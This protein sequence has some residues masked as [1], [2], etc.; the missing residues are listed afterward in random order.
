MKLFLLAILFSA[1]T[2]TAFSQK[3]K[4]T[5]VAIKTEAP[6]KMD[7]VLDDAVWQNVPIATDFV[8]LQPNAGNHE[9]QENRTTVKII[10]DN[11]A[12]YVGARMYEKDPTKIAREFA[13]R[14]QVGNADFIG[15]IFDTYKDGINGSGF[16]VTSTNG[17]FDAKYAPNPNG[18]TED[19]TWNAVWTSKVNIDSLGWT[20]EMKIPYSALRFAKKDVQTWGMNLI[21]KRQNVQQQLFWN[22]L[23]PKMS[24]LMNQEGIL[25]GLEKIVPPVR[26][27]FYPYFST[28]V[29]HYPYNTPGLA[30]TT[31]SV[32]GGMDV[33][34]GIN[35]S[36]TLDLTLI[37]D[38][39]Q[40]QSDNRILNLT[41]FEVK[42]NENRSFFT[43]GTELFNK[44]N[45]FYSRR[46]GGQPLHYNDITLNDHEAIIKNP[47]E[48]KL[49]N[50]VKLSGRLSN[51]LGIGIF[52]GL[53]NTAYA[54]IEDSTTGN[55][56]VVQTSP[57]TNYNIIVLD[58]NLKNNSA[59]TFI[60]T[61][62]N[63][64]GKD[65]SAD[66]G[67][68][69]FNLNNKKNT[70]NLAGYGLMSNKFYKGEQT[71]TGYNYEV[72]FGKVAGNFTWNV[73]QD[74]VD[75][76]YD[77]N[78][79]G[80][81]FNNNYLEH[82]INLQYANYKPKHLFT[83]WNV[84]TNTYSS[85]RV[86]PSTYQYF[87][88]NFGANGSFKN[89]WQVN[90]NGH[91]RVEGNDFYEPRVVGRVFKAPQNFV[92]NWNLSTNRAKVLSGGFWYSDQWMANGHGGHGNDLELFYNVRL[93]N[94]FSFGQD[95]TI[96][97]RINYTGFATFDNTGAD[98]FALRN[99]HT[100]DNIFTLKYTFSSI[101]GL[102]LRLRHYWS[103]VNN[104]EFFSLG[105][106]GYLTS[107][108]SNDFNHNIDQNANI[109][110]VDMIY[111]WQFSPGSELSLA[112]KNSTYTN[113]N[114]ATQS[115]LRN[116]NDTVNQPQNNNFSLK[117][118][119]YIDFQS[120][121]KHRKG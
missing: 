103:K 45:L 5:L 35:E 55:R 30:N 32:N 82:N 118:L 31:T 121:R 79:L 70:Y 72:V 9:K 27:A 28:Y 23:D 44:G 49:I 36:F 57:V 73:S 51:G 1:I 104:K 6:P 96:S 114:I 110:N 33:K 83:Q 34:Y 3:P 37:P 48:T 88:Q 102:N 20:C 21:R 92:L 11:T 43:E 107:L 52:N 84:W 75:S 87:N 80:I 95:I 42:Y 25:T 74:R 68:V 13:T 58:Q 24:G 60:N 100:V 61:N 2:L 77:P 56:R 69:V 86:S 26:L 39:G 81:L 59:I 89:F 120:L 65:Y 46:V 19:E 116:L 90:I 53:T 108:T 71:V 66:V 111:V 117:V 105:Q 62:V 91:Y 112:W 119:Y 94:K 7:G 12:I 64:F 15:I 98:V 113:T 4:K 85:Y 115:Y 8:E 109:W 63:R 67:G 97:P 40:V 18:N 54:T 16:F 22:E 38:F 41:P 17:Q 78:D 47:T 101:M 93:S 99:V 29:N 14:D 10:Y 106:D 76:K 50:A